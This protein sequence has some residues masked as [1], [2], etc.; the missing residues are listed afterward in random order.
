MNKESTLY[1]YTKS[2]EELRQ[3]ELREKCSKIA[4][5]YE[6]FNIQNDVYK[7]FGEWLLERAKTGYSA[8][9]TTCDLLDYLESKGLSCPR[10]LNIEAEYKDWNGCKQLRMISNGRRFGSSDPFRSDYGIYT[11][12]KIAQAY[13]CKNGCVVTEIVPGVKIALNWSKDAQ[14]C[15]TRKKWRERAEDNEELFDWLVFG[16]KIGICFGILLA[17]GL[18]L[19]GVVG[20]VGFLCVVIGS[21]L[22]GVFVSVALLR[23]H[24][25]TRHMDNYACRFDIH[26]KSIEEAKQSEYDVSRVYSHML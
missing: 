25:M 24:E 4:M 19:F 23:E 6:R 17:V 3:F 1:D 18:A 7:M 2:A 26:C 22:A 11:L 21:V 12:W 16:A 10:S 15:I 20:V 5:E 9:F 13:N 8:T 14:D